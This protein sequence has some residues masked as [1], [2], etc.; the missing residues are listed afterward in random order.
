MNLKQIGCLFIVVF[1]IGSCTK[2]TPQWIFDHRI[3]LPEAARPLSVV[4]LHGKLWI[5]DPSNYRLLQINRKGKVLDSI[6]GIKRPMNTDADNGQ[7]YIPEY[8]TDTIWKFSNGR[9]QH[10]PITAKLEAPAGLAVHHDTIVMADF[11]NHR[12]VVQE[13]DSTK[14]IG[15]KGHQKGQLYYPIDVKIRHGKIYVADAYN[16]RV[17]VFKRNGE[18]IRVIGAADSLKVASGIDLTDEEMAVTDQEHNR[19]M[20][21]N[22]QGQLLQ[23]L[24]DAIHYPTDVLISNDT[25]F[26]ANFK[27][28]HLAVYV[29]K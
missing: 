11:Y 25:L 27:A 23:R 17:Q 24:T 26:V 28:N 7:L 21:Y 5:S 3:T 8:L 9:L 29:K 4:K 16:H 20:I 15:Q 13:R 1:M 12:I 10:V 18:F 6:S 22:H 19:V 2:K 14:V